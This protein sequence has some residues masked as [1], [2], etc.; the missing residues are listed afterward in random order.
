MKTHHQKLKFWL[1]VLVVF[2]FV[3]CSEPR[4]YNNTVRNNFIRS[5]Q[6]EPIIVST[7][8]DTTVIP[9]SAKSVYKQILMNRK[10]EIVDDIKSAMAHF[11]NEIQKSQDKLERERYDVIKNIYRRDIEYDQA[12]YDREK[13]YL[14]TALNHNVYHDKIIDSIQAL[15]DAP[16]QIDVVTIKYKLSESDPIK[17]ERGIFLVD[18]DSTLLRS[19]ELNQTPRE[20]ITAFIQTKHPRIWG[21]DD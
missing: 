21:L 7:Q 5:L 13:M 4:T 16:P 9:D 15:I 2:V 6:I 14:D 20:V 11:Q 1:Y 10:R 19:A 12:G 3:R 17:V 8:I 18:K